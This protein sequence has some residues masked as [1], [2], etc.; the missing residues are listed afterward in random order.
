M[1]QPVEVQLLSAAQKMIKKQINNIF[2]KI[3]SQLKKYQ[4]KTFLLGI[5]D[6]I[7]EK[8]K[9]EIKIFLGKKI[10]KKLKKT[11]DF[12]NPDILIEI[13][14]E[15]NEINFNIK[16]LYIFGYYQKILPGIP[17]TRW[18]KKR[19]QTSVQEEIGEIVLKE[20]R[21][22]DHSFHGCGRE[23]ID[24]ITIG[25]GRPFVIE[26]K[27]PKKRQ[28]NLKKI[29]EKI[30]H[31]SKYV[32]VANL[33]FCEKNK[34]RQ[35]KLASPKKTYETEIQLE[36]PV[37]KSVLEKICKK[38]SNLTIIQKT[39][40]RVLKR[41]ANLKRKKKIYYIELISYHPKNPIL[42]IES[43]SG[44]YIKE[45]IN[46]DEDRTKPSFSYFLNQ[47]CFVKKLKV[48]KIDF[49]NKN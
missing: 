2:K 23:D 45:L 9:K 7:D 37:L 46:G 14:F 4:F 28:I 27:N 22:E 43:E 42:K 34:I 8:E 1:G 10:E 16:P 33:N 49:N 48:I 40:T 41:R 5:K 38:F 18:H 35:I 12:K 6:K 13:N 19:Y 32:K 17:Q 36:K 39:P 15:K 31:N 26:I 25:K 20:S 21:G 44:T 47:K 24:V 3:S 29:E 11:A 30:N